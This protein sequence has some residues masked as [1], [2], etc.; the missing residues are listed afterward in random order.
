[1]RRRAFIASG[2]LGLAGAAALAAPAIAQSQPE[3]KWRLASSFPKSLDTL[4]GG[5]ERFTKQIADGDRQQVPD[6]RLR[7]RRD[8]AA[9]P[10]ARRGAEQ[11]RRDRPY[12]ELLLRRQGPDLRDRF[13]DPVRHECAPDECLDDAWRRHGSAAQFLQGL[14]CL[15]PAGRQYRGAD[16]RL[17]AQ[18]DQ[19]GRRSEGHQ[20]ADCRAGRRRCSASSASWRS[21]SPAATS[22]RRSKRARSTRPN[23]SAPTTTKSSASTRSRNIITIPAGGKGRPRTPIYINLDQW[24]KLPK[25]YQAIVTGAA[26]DTYNGCSANTIP[27]MSRRCG[28]WSPTAPNCGRFRARSS[29]PLQ[30]H[31]G[32]LCR[33]IA[34]E[35]EMEGDLRALEAIP[36]RRD[37]VVPAERT[38][39]STPIWRRR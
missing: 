3:I 12:R 19:D 37:P 22:I 16:G 20:D 33:A 9:V 32:I 34:E 38:A 13:D 26:A 2:G 30:G 31:A 35:P 39:A 17:V 25:S 18:G 10:G 6:P 5:A 24:N 28:A 27:T 36:R 11:H 23:G 21:R 29:T 1:M 15:Q 8:R 7:R 14:Q 4:Y